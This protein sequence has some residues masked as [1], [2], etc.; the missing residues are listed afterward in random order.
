MSIDPV[1]EPV[2]RIS[3][4]R[5]GHADLPGMIKY[6]TTDA[7]DILERASARETAARTVA[8]YLARSLL[9]ALGMEVRSHVVRIGPVVARSEWTDMSDFEDVDANPV[10]CLDVEASEQM[11]EV[12][13]RAEIDKDTVGGQ[14]EILGFDLPIGLGSY[15]HYD[16]RLDGLLGQAMMS[17]PAIKG[18]E[19]GDGFAVSGLPGSVSHDEMYPGSGGVKR[20]TNRAGGLEGGITNGEVLR[21]RAAM[22]PISTL[23]RPLATVDMDSGDE[24]AA[25]RERSDVCAVPAAAV[26]GEQMVAWVL[27]NEVTR[28]FGGDTLHE[29]QHAVSDY[30]DRVRS[31]FSPE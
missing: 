15:V 16:R 13:D 21:V 10:R 14:F 28:K 11:V 18:V 30:R 20:M 17:I 9:A 5:P 26:V 1:D 23:M 7:R 27:A 8:G 2:N 12:I 24:A 31:R 22:K 29:L 6:D 19:I 3:R 25:V 4:P